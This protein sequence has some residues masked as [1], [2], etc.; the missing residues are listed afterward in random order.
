MLSC[1]LSAVALASAVSAFA[2]PQNL[3]VRDDLDFAIELV[4][5]IEC[6]PLAGAVGTLVMKS[7]PQSPIRLPE[8]GVPLGFGADG[9]LEE[10]DQA[11]DHFIFENCTSSFM[12]LTP[13]PGEGVYY[14]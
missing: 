13:L 14:G 11:T 8:E 2:G 10:V 4:E 9:T 5:T 6:T 7:T 1:L 3:K 12:E